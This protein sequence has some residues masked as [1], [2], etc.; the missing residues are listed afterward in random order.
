MSPTFTPLSDPSNQVVASN[1][2]NN[3]YQLTNTPSVRG[4]FG[5]IN[6]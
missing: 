5:A 4:L 3:E 6:P 2:G 1:L